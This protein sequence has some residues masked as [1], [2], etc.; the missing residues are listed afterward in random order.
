MNKGTKLRLE[1]HNILYDI[2]HKN[3]SMNAISI[4]SKLNLYDSKDIAFILNVCLN[5]MRYSFH[6]KKI[7]NLYSKK[8]TKNHE[9]IL[10]S[11]AI[12]QIVYLDF[13]EYAVIN[14]S[15][16]VAKK[17]NIYHGF[18][19][20][21]LK[22]ICKDKER[23]FKLKITYNDLPIWFK[24]NTNYLSKSDKDSFLKCITEEPD[25]HIVF[26]NNKLIKN[27]EGNLFLTSK[28]SGFL[29]NKIKFTNLKSYSNGNWWIQD[30]SSAFPLNNIHLNNNSECF[31]LC[32]AP[33]G[34]AFQLLSREI[35]VTLN[36]KS[37]SRINLLNANL[38]R[39]KL[40]TNIYNKD[41]LELNT[42]NKYDL[43]ILDAPCTAVGTI[44]RNPEIFFRKINPEIN[45]LLS[46][47][48]KMLDKASKL[49]RN[50]GEI[51]Y[52]VCSFLKNETIEQVNKFLI[53]NTEFTVNE[54]YISNRDT[55]YKKLIHQKYMLT[56]PQSI[57]NFKIDGY[58]AALLKKNST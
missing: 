7:I 58:F 55:N 9:L 35:K 34:K 48:E 52:M 14:C 36:D 10:L 53:K 8:K 21:L 29:K 47:Q 13:K 43:V 56:L 45:K 18:I 51:L 39:L 32:A 54:F 31:D 19:N 30:Y 40:K 12:A 44:R 2:F 16:E 17:L 15:V 20:S 26:K 3:I 23:L 6:L 50:N 4:K 37:K 42:K 57:N 22:K 41:V 25:I 38:E 46:M 1:I 11:S 33:G 5:T 27:F 49:L 28:I 24:K